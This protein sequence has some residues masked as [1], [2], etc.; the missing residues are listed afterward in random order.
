MGSK[1]YVAFNQPHAFSRGQTD[2]VQAVIGAAPLLPG[3]FLH[4]CMCY[5]NCRCRH[6]TLRRRR[7]LWALARVAGNVG[8]ALI[9]RRHGGG[10]LRANILFP[11]NIGPFTSIDKAGRPSLKL[12]RKVK[13]YRHAN[14]PRFVE[15]ISK[16]LWI[17]TLSC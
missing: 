4:I 13:P 14:L 5:H 3:A 12:Q 10:L 7:S 6:R 17:C 15:R 11:I 16:Y 9:L 1:S 2:R 8:I